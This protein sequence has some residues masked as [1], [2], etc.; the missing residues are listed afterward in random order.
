MRGKTAKRLKNH[1]LELNIDND[2]VTERELKTMI[3]RAK[4]MWKKDPLFKKAFVLYF[5]KG[6][7]PLDE[8]GK[9]I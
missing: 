7:I 1:V 6:L 4:K 5:N 9:E 2:K 8:D 3:R